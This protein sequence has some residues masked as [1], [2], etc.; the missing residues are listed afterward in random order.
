LCWRLL[1][2]GLA[3]E[4]ALIM[5]AL[6]ML[7]RV[8]FHYLPFL[9]PDIVAMGIVAAMAFNCHRLTSSGKMRDA[10]LTGL[11]LGLAVSTKYYLGVLALTI[12][13]FL[14]LEWFIDETGRLRFLPQMKQLKWLIVIAISSAAIFLIIHKIIFLIIPESR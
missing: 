13:L 4:T 14:L 12:T 9:M 3:N 2:A 1:R 11:W 5:T 7:D 6:L 10:I 8:V